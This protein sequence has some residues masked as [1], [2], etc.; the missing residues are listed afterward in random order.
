MF[1]VFYCQVRLPVAACYIS[2]EFH[3]SA[4]IKP[5]HALNKRAQWSHRAVRAIVAR[6]VRA[7]VCVFCTHADY[8]NTVIY[9][10]LNIWF[11][12]ST[13][14]NSHRFAFICYLFLMLH[15]FL[16]FVSFRLLL[17]QCFSCSFWCFF[18]ALV[19]GRKTCVRIHATIACTHSF[20]SVEGQKRRHNTFL[21]LL[22]LLR[23]RCAQIC[24]R[25]VS[26]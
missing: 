18:R 10:P 6:R 5:W 23:F 24:L 13:Q 4:P 9:R 3:L 26:R 11:K 14:C 21:L 25:S 16:L 15:F 8:H 20:D 12:S 1:F 17:L 2:W 19:A 7:R 22:Y